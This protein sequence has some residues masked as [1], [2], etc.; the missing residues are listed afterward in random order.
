MMG[1]PSCTNIQAL[2]C[3]RAELRLGFSPA[4]RQ[5]HLAGSTDPETG[6]ESEIS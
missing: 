6:E 3:Q 4:R 5:T 2:A 1:F